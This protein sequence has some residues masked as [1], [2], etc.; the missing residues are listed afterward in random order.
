MPSFR[1]GLVT[2]VVSERPGFQRVEVDGEPA[3]VLVDLTGPVAE[4]DRVV[5]N[6]TA[7]ELG[8]GTGGSHV[9]HWNLERAGWRRPG[10]GNLLKLRYTSVQA[11]VGAWTEQDQGP[12][13]GRDDVPV[14]PD[15][16]GLVVVVATLH[17]L[18]APVTAAVGAQTKGAKG[19]KGAKVAWVMDDTAALPCALSDLAT[20]LRA[21]GLVHLTVSCGQAFGGDREAVSVPDGL[22]AAAAAGADLAV[23]APGP[24]LAGTASSVGFGAV[25]AAGHAD[26]AAA[27]GASTALA[28]RA[29]R[30]DP[31][32][33]HRGVSHHTAT[34]LALAAR[35][36][37]VPVPEGPVGRE[38]AQLLGDVAPH[39]VVPVPTPDLRAVVGGEPLAVRSMGR[40]LA[41]DDLALGAA[42]AAGAW[43]GTLASA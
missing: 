8:L 37:V 41:G 33:R 10:A 18:L 31:R 1:T 9:V 34:V 15:L 2:S 27:L 14:L 19:A 7:V 36:H 16:S 40:P 17:S 26:A 24:G 5:V 43:A 25:A 20:A 12:V 3:Y 30:H 28:V 39:E 22:V 29:S 13:A 32:A 21:A 35:T 42:A 38:L 6:T 4:G 23:V 11:D